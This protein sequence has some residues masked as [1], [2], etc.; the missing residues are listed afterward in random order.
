MSEQ[1]SLN[2]IYLFIK[3]FHIIWTV[4]IAVVLMEKHTTS[5]D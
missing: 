4:I 1:S 3:F 5:K 2:W